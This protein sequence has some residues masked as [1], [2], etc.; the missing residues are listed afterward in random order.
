MILEKIVEVKKREVAALKRMIPLPWLE[1]TVREFPPARDFRKA[2]RDQIC[3]IIAEVKRSSPSKGRIRQ[4]FDPFQI[5][6]LYQENGAQAISVLTDEAFFEGK[7]RYLS[8]IK[9][10]VD[11]PLLRKDFVIDPYQIYETRFLGG[12]ALLLIVTLLDAGKLREYILLADKLGL[13]PLVEVHTREELDKALAA[14]AEII[15]INN[16]D[17]RTF[18]A[19]IKTT[20]DLAPL[21]PSDR[22]VVAESGINSREDIE[23]LMKAGIHC[24][25]IGEAFM[26]AEDIGGK[27][28]EL[29]GAGNTE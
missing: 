11:L 16:R 28:R 17:L 22:M 20:L 14:G 29:L 3:S 9:D 15:G 25:L 7:R 21:I 19:D 2:L 5:A 4:E 27:L 8:D 23:Q 26:R 13:T 1:A 18:S 6:T 10:I 12:D 24:F